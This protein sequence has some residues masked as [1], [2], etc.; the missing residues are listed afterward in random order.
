MATPHA[1]CRIMSL[2]SSNKQSPPLCCRK[3]ISSSRTPGSLASSQPQTNG[4]ALSQPTVSEERSSSGNPLGSTWPRLTLCLP[5]SPAPQ[6]SQME[7]QAPHPRPSA[8]ARQCQW[9]CNRAWPGP[10][11]TG[12]EHFEHYSLC[13][14]LKPD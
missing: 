9:P 6:G 14:H 11:G 8:A 7:S 12:K 10:A 3:P 2:L 4:S 5:H 1:L 13:C